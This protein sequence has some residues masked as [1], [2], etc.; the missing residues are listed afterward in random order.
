MKTKLIGLFSLLFITAQLQAKTNDPAS[1]NEKL[2][3]AFKETF[4]QA[5][6]V[7]WKENGESYFVHFQENAI[8]SEIEYDHD[9]NFVESER[10]YTD[11]DML[12]LHLACELHKQFAGKTVY[13]VTETN[14]DTETFYYIKLQDDKEWVTVKG[15]SY[16]SVEVVEKFN[17]HS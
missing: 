7:N 15:T 4:P 11:A 8:A 12:P 13:G 2:I 6:T 3:K 16:G 10:Y 9:G 5:K 1:V 17:K 14:T